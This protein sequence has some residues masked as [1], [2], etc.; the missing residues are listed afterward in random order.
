MEEGSWRLITSN[1]ATPYQKEQKQS[2]FAVYFAKRVEMTVQGWRNISNS[3][4]LGLVFEHSHGTV[5]VLL[6][7][8]FFF[9]FCSHIQSRIP[10]VY[11]C[12]RFPHEFQAALGSA[13]AARNFFRRRWHWRES[14]L[15]RSDGFFF[16]LSSPTSTTLG[17]DIFLYSFFFHPFFVLLWMDV[18][19][20]R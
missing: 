7:A 6:Y 3:P 19:L 20:W 2:V 12:H 4:I 15:C 11:F 8:F 10:I 17:L 16:L 5:N 18:R 14:T 1:A 9:P 13:V